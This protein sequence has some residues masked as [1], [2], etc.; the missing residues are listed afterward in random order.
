MWEVLSK[1]SEKPPI[2]NSVPTTWTDIDEDMLIN[3]AKQAVCGSI[4][5]KH[6]IK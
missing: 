6:K 1:A 3:A 5:L 4:F 2:A